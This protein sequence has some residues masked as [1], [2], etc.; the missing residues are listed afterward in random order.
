M[1]PIAPQWLLRLAAFCPLMVPLAGQHL[2]VAKCSIVC[3]NMTPK[4]PVALLIGYRWNQESCGK[5]AIVLETKRHKRFC[6]DPQAPWVQEAM[7]HL[8][9][10]AVARTPHS[11]TFEKQIGAVKPGASTVKPGTTAAPSGMPEPAVSEPRATGDSRSPE[12]T[13]APKE[14]QTTLGTSPALPAGVPS[15][16]G[17]GSLVTQKPQDGRPPAGPTGPEFVDMAPVS[18]VGSWQT[19]TH[20]HGA[21]ES[22]SAETPSTEHPS[23]RAL[24][25]SYPAPEENLGSESQSPG[26][27]A[28]SPRPG[29]P[30]STWETVPMVTHTGAFQ[31]GGAGSMAYASVV[32]GSSEGTPSREP[33]ASG[34]WTPKA[35]EPVHATVDPQRLGVLIT[36]VPDSQAATRRQAVGLLAFLGLLFCLGVAMFAYQSL[37]GCPRKMAGEMV[38]GLRYVPRSCGANSYVLVPV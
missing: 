37:Q 23:T 20:Q 29:D 34:S 11:G 3:N 19:S 16:S 30:Q 38:E 13:P 15:S 4:I 33:A 25:T 31:D 28:L 35:E 32:P 6:A 5:P 22:P 18:T 8:D 26:A 21:T 2:G 10:Q 14:A 1:A 27:P 12:P 17:S 36:P 9:R 24:T 7:K